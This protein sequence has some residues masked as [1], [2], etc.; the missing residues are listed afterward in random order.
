MWTLLKQTIDAV[1]ND[2]VLFIY[3]YEHYESI[4]T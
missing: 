3:E 1:F 2:E 4:D